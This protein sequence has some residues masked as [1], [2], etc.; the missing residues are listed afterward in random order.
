M[1]VP[2][3][4]TCASA[5]WYSQVSMNHLSVASRFPFC[6]WRKKRR[7]RMMSSIQP[8]VK[9]SWHI[10]ALD[11]KFSPSRIG[12]IYW[13]L[14]FADGK[15][16]Q[17]TVSTIVLLSSFRGFLRKK[18]LAAAQANWKKNLRESRG[19]PGR[20]FRCRWLTPCLRNRWVVTLFYL[21]QNDNL[22]DW[23]TI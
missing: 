6:V 15:Y 4:S 2:V 23:N 13:L 14:R 11:N 21:F 10:Q 22:H 7:K 8:S 5:K 12:Q 19:I 3:K 1:R 20:D 16:R 18:W 9:L 17:A